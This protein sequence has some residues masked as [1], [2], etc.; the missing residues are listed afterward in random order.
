MKR[1]TN[2]LLLMVMLLLSSIFTFGQN[3]KTVSGFVRDANGAGVQGASIMIKGSK[4]GGTFSDE[5]GRFS[6]TASSSA[7]LVISA[8]GYTTQEVTV[9]GS[10]VNVTLSA[11]DNQLNEVV[12]T[13]M[14][15]GRQKKSLGYATSV[16]KAEDITRVGSPSFATALY[17]KA[18]GVN[19]GA[20]PGGA[21]SAVNITVRGLNSITGNTQP[22][23][24]LDG[25]P[26]R[27]GEAN[28]GNYWGDQRLR[29]NGLLDINP[30]DIEDLTILKGASAAALYGS[31]A[32]NGVLLI[33]T[34]KGKGKGL[35]VSA[36]LNYS[37][38]NV[39]YLPRY[40]NVRGPGIDS[41]LSN[42]GQAEDG[43]VYVDRDG[44]GTKETRGVGGFS[45]NFGP[46]FDGQPTLT[47][48]GT[49]RPYVAQKDNYKALFQT[50][51]NS[52]VNVAV[53]HSNDFSNTRFSLT[54]QSNEGVSL[55]AT[56]AKNIANLNTSFKIGK[57][58][59]TD[60]MINYINQKTH[61]RP[62][63]VDRMINNFTGMMTRFDNA[64]WYMNKYKTSLGYKY[65]TGTNPS[66]TPDENIIYNGFKGDIGDYVWNVKSN[67]EDEWN[68]RVIASMTNTW[69][70]INSLRLRARVGTDFTS[71]K[72]ESKNPTS[73][74]IPFNNTTGY[75]GVSLYNNSILYGD[76][77]LT[78]TKKIVSDLELNVMAG[79]TAT[80]EKTSAQSDGTNGGLSVEN[81]FD[82]RASRLPRT[83]NGDDGDRA[84]N[85]NKSLLRDAYI[86]TI[87]L[88]YKN[89]LFAEGTLRRDRTSTMH[90]DN[91]S[92]VYPSANASL[93]I[94]EAFKLPEV[95]NY[96]K[97][98][99][100]WGIVG[101]YPSQYL[102]NVAYTQSNLGVQRDGGFPILYTST[103]VDPYGNDKIRPEQKHEFEF[104]LE[105][106]LLNRHLQFDISYYNAQI[107]DQILPLDIPATSG[108]R[109]ILS[110]IGTLRN[111]GIEIGIKATPIRSK[112]IEWNIGLNLAKNV[113]KVEKLFTG[114]NELIHADYDGNAAVLKSV[115]GQPMGD[116]YIHAVKTNAKGEKVVGADGL[117]E[118]DGDNMV[119]VGNAMP[120][121][122]G[123]LMNTLTY[124]N[125]SLDIM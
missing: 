120:K 5:N 100:S 17:G 107:R 103:A 87:N 30:E 73:I 4:T 15:I 78:Y 83:K 105:T 122:T 69:Q 9:G 116:F 67:S 112:T 113:N 86:G 20:T 77:L 28:N 68:N 66:L 37:I 13:S 50:A 23:I 7:T 95:F 43:F 14:G 42:S 40:Q 82:F 65:V 58:W 44:D 64:D 110:N 84:S 16:V 21:T 106:E 117:Y 62:F 121:L 89:Y 92:F 27:N 54:R 53:S 59:T 26:I 39:A 51:H 94:S 36:N 12:V 52:N 90:P 75:Y 60:V 123:G 29:G 111:Q 22:L 32:V 97:L 46:K 24:V 104:G 101:N 71:S 1:S 119:K 96:A 8:V 125:F 63:S 18:P 118:L 6:I 115:V 25:I 49:M 3:Q 79:Y 48:D 108:A 102:A 2:H 38:D 19:I 109:K 85:Y 70:I 91:N 124:K 72:I 76:V 61:N 57:N 47:W 33:T 99:A 55:G 56:N 98:R 88:G 41:R 34:K 114:S 93:V 45:V 80:Q 81:W 31:E 11:A 74:P 35:N 10:T